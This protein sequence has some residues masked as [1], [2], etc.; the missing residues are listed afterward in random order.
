[1][2]YI[3]NEVINEIRNKT[4]IVDVVSKY[5][6]LNK[7]GKNYIGVCPFH[8]DHSPSMSVSTEDVRRTLLSCSAI[9]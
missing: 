5:V 3:S 6:T 7:A 4:D 1:M 8:D 2:A 9:S